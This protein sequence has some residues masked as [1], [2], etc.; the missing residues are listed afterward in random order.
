MESISNYSF[1]NIKNNFAIAVKRS[2]SFGP[3]ADSTAVT[4]IFI[5]AFE[6]LRKDKNS[7]FISSKMTSIVQHWDF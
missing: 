1:K 3:V 2:C 7:F 6:N 5:E 4:D